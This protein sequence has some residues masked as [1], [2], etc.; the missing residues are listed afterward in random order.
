MPP[1]RVGSDNGLS[2]V[3]WQAII[4]TDV[5]LFVN[6]LGITAVKLVDIGSPQK[7]PVMRRPFLIMPAVN[8]LAP[9]VISPSAAMGIGY[10]E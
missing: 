8:N 7:G 2:T 10:G 6:A 4:Q 5:G 9:W 1:F 3:Q